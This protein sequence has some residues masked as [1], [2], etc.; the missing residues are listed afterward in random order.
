MSLSTGVEAGSR[1]FNGS[2]NQEHVVIGGQVGMQFQ[3]CNEYGQEWSQKLVYDMDRPAVI[4][5]D[6]VRLC[7]NG[8]C[9]E[10][11][12]VKLCPFMKSEREW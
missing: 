4:K 12:V 11:V 8:N 3:I 9:F 5:R 10:A 1:E 2:F 7:V 6:L